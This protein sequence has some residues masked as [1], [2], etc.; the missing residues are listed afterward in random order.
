MING[1]YTSASGMNAEM[2]KM[3]VV[4]NNLANASTTGFK[5]DEAVFTSFPNTLIHRINDRLDQGPAFPV[6]AQAAPIL[7]IVGHGVQTEDVVTN[8]SDGSVV[9]TNNPLDLALRGNALFTLQRSDGSLAY[10][11]S[12]S[13]TMNSDGQ[14]CTKDGDLVLGQGAQAITVSGGNVVVDSS[15][16]V[17]V[18]AQETGRLLFSN[19]DPTRFSKLGEGL[20]TRSEA[21]LEALTD[22][23]P[24]KATVQQG[25]LEQ[26]NIQVVREM[27][28][29]IT[30][31]RSYEAN[32]KA[33]QLQNQTLDQVINQV[34]KPS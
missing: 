1:I 12:G 26:A 17:S 30:V 11:R 20:Y 16:K 32:S 6:T 25:F 4:A 21:P 31:S 8:F 13:F 18:D 33:L 14:L 9:A 28:N 3:D 15:G 5:K 29:L 27:V 22:G 24:V 10:T 2:E 7:G 19:W 23:A 34:G